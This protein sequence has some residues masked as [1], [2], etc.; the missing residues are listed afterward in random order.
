MHSISN[1]LG[2]IQWSLVDK[3]L[4]I[5]LMDEAPLDPNPTK[6]VKDR[7]IYFKRDGTTSYIDYDASSL[8]WINCMNLVTHWHLPSYFKYVIY[9]LSNGAT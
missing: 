1:K 4:Q 6:S 9:K 7:S 8:I 5:P 3:T 2:E